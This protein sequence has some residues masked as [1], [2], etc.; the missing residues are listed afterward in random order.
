MEPH[1]LSSRGS[2]MILFYLLYCNAKDKDQM[3]LQTM[4]SMRDEENQA[5]ACTCLLKV[6][7][8]D[9]NRYAQNQLAC[10]HE[11]LAGKKQHGERLRRVARRRLC[12]GNL[13]IF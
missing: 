1:E 13:A 6:E 7:T 9:A 8:T 4:L 10:R 11:I 3:M 5:S 12:I 2:M